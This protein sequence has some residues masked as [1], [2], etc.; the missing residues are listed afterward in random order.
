MKMMIATRSFT[1]TDAYGS[2]EV[3]KGERVDSGHELVK[4]FPD[5]WRD[6]TLQD[7]L[8]I[9]SDCIADMNERAARPAGRAPVSEAGKREAREADF[10]RATEALLERTALNQPTSE[11]QREQA[12]YDQALA[13]LESMDTRELAEV[14]ADAVRDYWF[15]RGWS[16]RISD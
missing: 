4:M 2:G 10:W 15:D 8:R 5:A 1:F 12:F 7:E 14:N 13:S 3:V 6:F 9:R 16:P 11:E